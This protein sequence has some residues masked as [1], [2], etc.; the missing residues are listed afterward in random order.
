M[1]N[2]F[3]KPSSDYHKCFTFNGWYVANYK[4]SKEGKML[5][6]KV[7]KVSGMN[8]PGEKNPIERFLAIADSGTEVE[9]TKKQVT[10]IKSAETKYLNAQVILNE[11][12]KKAQG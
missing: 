7:G 12:L 2:V 11:A 6:V 10:S 8:I 3:P 9:L 5:K 1:V 4:C